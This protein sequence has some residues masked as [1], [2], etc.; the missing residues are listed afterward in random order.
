M[1]ALL[2]LEAVA[3]LKLVRIDRLSVH[4]GSLRLYF[5]RRDGGHHPTVLALQAEETRAG[6]TDA[7]RYR[8][9]AAEVMQ[10]RVAL[11]QLLERLESEGQHVAGYGA[12]AKGNTLLNFC[13]IDTRLLDYTVDRNARKVG[14]YT[15]GMHI[16][17]RDVS[18]LTS[19][20]RRPD[21]L[22]V[23]PW[24]LADEIIAQQTSYRQRGGRFIIPVP[25]AE[26]L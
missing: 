10:S 18:A 5:S 16:P 9:F 8:T 11:L 26:V 7:A 20:D 23:L 3:G 22:L 15:P 6:I 17:V 2:R 24:N 4:G 13:R 25:R 1:T 19:D 12:P 14:L 21:Y